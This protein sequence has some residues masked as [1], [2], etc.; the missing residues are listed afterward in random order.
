M[1]TMS[2]REKSYV[3][4]GKVHLDDVCLGG[5]RNAGKLGRGS[6]NKV[7]IIA[8]V[9]FDEAGHPIYV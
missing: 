7:P 9:S 3:L 2:E 8:A 4:M 1:H 6:E 5:E